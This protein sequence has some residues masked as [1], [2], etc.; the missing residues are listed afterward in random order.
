M[1]DLFTASKLIFFKTERYSFK[2]Y[3]SFDTSDC[4]RPHFC[5]GLVLEGKGS[6]KDC[7]DGR[8][9][10]V[11]P[12][13]IIFVPVTS[14]YISSWHGEPDISYISMHFTFESNGVFTKQRMFCLQKVRTDN[15]TQMKADFEYT[16]E[17]YD[18]DEANQLIAIS[19]FYKVLGSILPLLKSKKAKPIDSRINDAI[20]YIE[21]NFNS[22]ITIET[23]ANISKISISRFYP[24]FKSAMGITPVDYI[25][26]YRINRAI[27][28]LI[29]NPE[30]TIESISDAVG[31]YSSAYFRRV[32]KKITGKTPREYK[33]T[34]VEI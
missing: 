5:L 32:F 13:D 24:C 14:R 7:S 18:K 27:I 22:D 11:E 19:C 9:I 8:I 15:F 1:S 20:E 3:N 21:K 2:Q 12:G 29:N 4:P 28:L 30:L 34:S 23:L 26:T 31:F 6:F 10:E 16:L 17:N 25:N 33:S